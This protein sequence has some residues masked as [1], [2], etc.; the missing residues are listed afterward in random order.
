MF[1]S[2]LRYVFNY[3]EDDQQVHEKVLNITN[4]ENAIKTIMRYHLTPVK[5]V[6]IKKT[7]N[8]KCWP[9][10]GKKGTLCTVSGNINWCSHYGKQYGGSSKY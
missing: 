1:Q 8:N 2:L 6:I 4:Q 7:R 5:M 10:C 9:G 3:K